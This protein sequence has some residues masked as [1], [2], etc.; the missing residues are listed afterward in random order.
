MPGSE[1]YTK[2]VDLRKNVTKG[3]QVSDFD[4]ITRVGEVLKSFKASYGP[5][6]SGV[7]SASPCLVFKPQ[8]VC[9][10]RCP[11]TESDNFSNP[12]LS[13]LLSLQA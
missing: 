12:S 4:E 10:Y 11:K 8:S 5:T 13:Q 2:V 6:S 3:L 7:N 9:M 1:M